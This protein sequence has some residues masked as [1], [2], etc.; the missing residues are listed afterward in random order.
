MVLDSRVVILYP[1]RTVEAF[2]LLKYYNDWI[3]HIVFMKNYGKSAQRLTSQNKL[4]IQT[5]NF[6]RQLVASTATID[7]DTVEHFV[8]YDFHVQVSDMKSVHAKVSTTCS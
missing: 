5:V 4:Q 3:W 6:E 2:D 7:Y 1:H 8:R